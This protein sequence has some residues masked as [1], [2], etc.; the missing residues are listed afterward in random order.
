MVALDADLWLQQLTLHI[1]TC[2]L[3]G[4]TWSSL[5]ASVQVHAA[6]GPA[7]RNEVAFFLT[8][9]VAMQHGVKAAPPARVAW[10][11]EAFE[12]YLLADRVALWSSEACGMN[13]R[14]VVS[15]EV[16]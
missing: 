14:P 9:L 13:R 3:N 8:S 4:V 5:P 2:D 15:G 1:S 6:K 16:H 7:E 12:T 10:I 11:E